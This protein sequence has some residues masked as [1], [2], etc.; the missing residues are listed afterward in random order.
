MVNIA[1]YN[2]RGMCEYSK[3]QK[4]FKFL[5]T[6]CHDIICLQ[7]TH[8]K[9]SDEKILKSM[10]GGQIFYAHGT[11]QSRGCAVL[12]KR[13]ISTKI[14]KINCDNNG[15]YIIID[16]LLSDYRLTL[17]NVYA[18]N[19]D[20]VTFFQEV[21]QKTEELQPESI[22]MVGDFNTIMK[23]EDKKCSLSNKPGHPK[24][25]LFLN[26]MLQKLNM[27]DIWRLRNPRVNRFT[28]FKSSPRI[29]MERIDFVLM[30]CNLTSFVIDADIDPTFM[31]D[32]SIPHVTLK[33]E[34]T[35]DKGPGYWKLNVK[36]LEQ[37]EFQEGIIDIVN[38]CN[39]KYNDIWLRW[40]MIKMKCRGYAIKYGTRKKKARKNV[41]E[42]LQNKL[43]QVQKDKE[44]AEVS[45]TIFRDHEEQCV[46]LQK[47]IETII[48]E[49]ANSSSR[50]NQINWMAYGEKISSYYFSLEKTR[51]KKPLI[52]IKLDD[53][54]IVES[55]TV[56]LQ[57][58]R[59]FYE[60]LFTKRD[61]GNSDKFLQDLTLPQVKNEDM[62]MLEA[63]ISLQ[64][65]EIAIKQLKSN[66]CPGLDGI[67][68]ELYKKFES[69]VKYILHSVLLKAT[70][71]GYLHRSAR[72]GVIS[73]LEKANRDQLKISSWR[74]LSLLCSDYKVYAKIVANR[75]SVVTPYLIHE[76]QTAF[77]KGRFIAQNLMEL[78]MVIAQAK[79]KKLNATITAVNFEKAYDTVHWAS[80]Y[81]IF[82]LFGFGPNFINMVKI[83]QNK[84]SSA[85]INNGFR[86]E[87]F[88]IT[89]GLRQGCPLSCQ[90]FLYYIEV[91]GAKIRQCDAIE[92]IPCVG[93][94][95]T[96]TLS[97]YADDLWVAMMH[98]ETCYIALYNI[99][100]E[101]EGFCGLKVNYD[102]TEVLRI[103]A[104]RWSDA[105]FYSRLPLVW[106]DG[107]VKI[108]G[109][110]CTG[111]DV[112]MTKINFKVTM[113]KTKSICDLWTKRSGTLLGR[114]AVVNT[115]IIPNFI[116]RLSVIRTPTREQFNQYKKI[117]V[118]FLWE[119][120]KPKIAYKRLI[121]NY[122]QGGIKLVDLETK[123]TAMK[124][125]WIQVARLYPE[126]LWSKMVN[127]ISPLEVEIL[128]QC[129][130]AQK[131]VKKL[132]KEG[133]VMDVL[134]AW[135]K[136]N[137]RHPT[138]AS[139]VK[140]QVLW[141]NSNIKINSEMLCYKNWIRAGIVRFEQLITEQ[142]IYKTM[143]EIQVE[144]GKCVNFIEYYNVRNSIP[145]EWML[146][147]KKQ[148]EVD[149]KKPATQIVKDITKCTGIVYTFLRDKWQD[150]GKNRNKWERVLN[151]E[152]RDKTW[153][154]MYN[155]T[156]KL[157]LVTKLRIFQFKI[158][159]RYLT[160]NET[161]ARWDKNID[162]N[163]ALC[164][165]ELESVIH[166]M[167]E[168]PDV[169]KLWKALTRWFD[170]YCYI[171]LDLDCKKVIFNM[172][173][174]EFADLVNTVILITKYY[175]YAQRC[176]GN[177][178]NFTE[179]VKAITRYK[180]TELAV[181]HKIGKT[182][183]YVNK[184][185]MFD[186]V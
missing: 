99:L 107:P 63:P 56:I 118:E 150:D 122:E 25:T 77:I 176:K 34:S 52:R 28:W 105:Q 67:G 6:K 136:I 86:S 29:M 90:A 7:E 172:Y 26:E 165:K 146:T 164:K 113:E 50:T 78:Q 130:I 137:F 174:D 181:A 115:L 22:V 30:S 123:D 87:F 35:K 74:P 43:Y 151:I 173:K 91:L 71:V 117:I 73:L 109:I 89:R 45:D 185:C 110:M 42:A 84:T 51:C 156:C 128:I 62:K 69:E 44:K 92:G 138:S 40:E 3:R 33:D 120:K 9:K 135:S 8:T 102:K 75:M 179:L 182:K 169:Q 83:C 158:C 126:T 129:N 88:E 161:M 96:K 38:E 16:L 148:V 79:L 121:R 70:E 101:Y 53:D 36:H 1:T 147:V 112:E 141:F 175:V 55:Q 177:K 178:L 159:H 143:E 97:Q 140:S 111:N 19:E 106:T 104:L 20:D 4:V 57:E 94:E 152:I 162:G 93:N 98:K 10:S 184:W 180:S 11:T 155:T 47:N 49:Q 103:G 157:T 125:K 39:E 145:K 186:M 65:I 18:P 5:K 80:M 59:K 60:K 82:E 114:V 116:Y 68:I 48:Q 21:L 183:K 149:V 32:H 81:K 76:D 132:I 17:V 54:E 163:C 171:K 31:S 13:N 127:K 166:L 142:G 46:L 124:V 2:V 95:N 100:E 15:R 167:W 133:I 139:D 23:I 64:E 168:C 108:L 160:T 85:V 41:L 66:K 27:V 119:S 154:E 58:V 12:I 153:E 14:F 24:C 131:D 144:F 170:R 72:Q 37:S 61:I 134:S